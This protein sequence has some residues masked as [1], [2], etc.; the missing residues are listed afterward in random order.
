[1]RYWR[2]RDY[3]APLL[4]ERLRDS[5]AKRYRKGRE[6]HGSQFQGDPL[7]HADEEVLDTFF[8]LEAARRERTFLRSC[9]AVL[10]GVIALLVW[11]K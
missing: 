5:S 7:A 8:Y 4:P 1:M 2:E 6:E 10:T 11:R 3:W 9:V